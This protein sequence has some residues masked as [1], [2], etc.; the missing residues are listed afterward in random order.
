MESFFFIFFIIGDGLFFSL[1]IWV[2]FL[3]V[4]IFGGIVFILRSFWFFD[5]LFLVFCCFIL[6]FE[7]IGKLEF[8]FLSIFFVNLWIDFS[9]VL[10]NK[11]L[12]FV[13]EKCL[14]FFVKYF[15]FIVFFNDIFLVRVLK[16]FNFFFCENKIKILCLD[17]YFEFRNYIYLWKYFFELVLFNYDFVCFC[18]Y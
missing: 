4:E 16:I 7:N 13:L 6:L 12:I 1:G 18:N 15:K 2:I 11:V 3:L 14:Y 10:Y 8:F 9:W 5:F 17:K